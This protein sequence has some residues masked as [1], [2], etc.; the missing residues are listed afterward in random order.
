MVWIMSLEFGST[1]QEGAVGCRG[2]S[3]LDSITRRSFPVRSLEEIIEA[4]NTSPSQT[5]Q[6]CLLLTLLHY[7]TPSFRGA[8][9]A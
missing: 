5:M 3:F 4:C 9:L 2:F 6:H 8:D 1:K 7:T